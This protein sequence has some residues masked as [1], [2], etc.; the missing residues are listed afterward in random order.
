MSSL[1]TLL[2][3]T[4]IS[5][6]K[7]CPEITDALLQID[8]SVL[9]YS[10]KRALFS[11]ISEEEFYKMDEILHSEEYMKYRDAIDR[12][13]VSITEELGDLISFVVTENGGSVN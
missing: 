3:N 11:H 1:D 8:Y 10:F 12:A 2:R 13:S 7:D 9:N 4:L 5:L 6:Y